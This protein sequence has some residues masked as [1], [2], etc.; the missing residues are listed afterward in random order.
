VRVVSQN[1][2]HYC[3]IKESGVARAPALR[4]RDLPST[5]SSRDHQGR[6]ADAGLRHCPESEES[7]ESN[8]ALRPLDR[9]FDGSLLG[10][11]VAAEDWFN[12]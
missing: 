7:V 11:F 5:M 6:S 10:E 4:G 12:H 2:T 3:H 8:R 9:P 1:C